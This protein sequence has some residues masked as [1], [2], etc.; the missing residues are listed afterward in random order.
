MN[1]A[2]IGKTLASQA[3]E[4][5]KNTVMEAMRPPDP[6]KVAPPP[7]NTQAAILSQI[8]A[9]QRPLPEDQE[10]MVLV[11]AGDEMLRV[12][13]VFVPNS[14]VL[15]FAGLDGPGNVTRLIT[16]VEAVQVVCKIVRVADGS[17][18]VRVN[19]LTP[20]PRA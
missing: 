5:T 3:I 19:I 17:R 20:K 2:N 8:Q 11:R 18:P 4:G 6:P 1:L 12:A 16:P 14:H 15:V 13:E 9:M 10:L 7:D